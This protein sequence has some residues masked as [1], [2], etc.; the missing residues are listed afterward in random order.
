MEKKFVVTKR[1]PAVGKSSVVSV[2]I[3]NDTLERLEAV[4]QETGRTRNE[5]I[6]MAINFALDNL[7]IEK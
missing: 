5:L 3:A 1:K 2:R 7:K 4:A 6:Q